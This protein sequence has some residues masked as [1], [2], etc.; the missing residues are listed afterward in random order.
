MAL[1]CAAQSGDEAASAVLVTRYRGF[2]RCKARSYFLAGADRED[3]YQEGLIGL[4]KAIRDYNPARQSS[5]RSFAELCITR[6]LITAIKSATRHKHQPLNS[7]VSLSRSTSVE[8]EG[9]RVLADILAAKEVG[10]PAEIVI[11]AWETMTIRDGF[12]Q[13]LSPFETDVLRLYVDGMSYQQVAESLGRHVKS[14]DNA[15]QRIKRK[16]EQQIE[17][18]RAC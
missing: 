1:I 3:V 11:G 2:V 4:F 9:D 12:F 13:V 5:F 14:V 10:D 17:R 16:M 8:E 6:Q 7:Y 18:C 15:L